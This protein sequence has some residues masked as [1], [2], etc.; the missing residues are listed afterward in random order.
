M[1]PLATNLVVDSCSSDLELCSS[2]KKKIKT[3]IFHSVNCQW[4][5]EVAANANLRNFFK[6]LIGVYVMYRFIIQFNSHDKAVESAGGWI[7]RAMS[8]SPLF[9]AK[10]GSNFLLCSSSHNLLEASLAEW[11]ESFN[12]VEALVCVAR[13][14]PR[15]TANATLIHYYLK[16][17]MRAREE[18]TTCKERSS[19]GPTVRHRRVA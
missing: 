11:L 14:L 7:T 1:C 2:H 19:P 8:L 3:A 18:H 9:V 5:C 4:F 16:E 12:M 6:E 17:Y 13:L 10:T 15:K